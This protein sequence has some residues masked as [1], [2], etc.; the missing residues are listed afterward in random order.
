MKQCAYCSKPLVKNIK[1]KEHIIP[2]GLIELFPEQNITFT[3]DRAYKDNN[4]Q[5]ISDV[6]KICNNGV[7]SE[8]DVYGIN[9]IKNNFMQKFK[10]DDNL[11]ISFDF[12]KM[13]RWLLKIAFNHERVEKNS[14]TWFK[15]NIDYING[16]SN[17]SERCSVFA[18]L[19]VDMNPL[20]E[21]NDLYLPLNIGS[22]LK[23]YDTGIVSYSGLMNG[24]IKESTTEPLNF[25]E[26]YKSYSF[27]FA[28]ARFILILWKNTTLMN[29]MEEV[30]NLE[31]LIETLFPYK[32]INKSEITLERANDNLSGR[33][34]NLIIG[35]VGMS[36]MDNM[37]RSMIPD[38]E[39]T[40][41]YFREFRN[42]RDRAFD[43]VF[44]DLFIDQYNKEKN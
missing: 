41:K 30:E 9:L 26:I 17:T 19:H 11:N 38:L 29:D 13:C 40:Q 35:N 8:L 27:R 36:I 23:F 4:G 33:F 39:G 10:P 24:K 7:L 22:D 2:K 44:E 5:S 32:N 28:S 18:G 15:R 42:S 1:T 25:K 37:V 21:E 14:C 16:I 31:I 6:C 43:N 20:G 34:S 3:A 12:D